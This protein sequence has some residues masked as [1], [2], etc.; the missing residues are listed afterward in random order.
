M[1]LLDTNIVSEIM[2]PMPDPTVLSWFNQ[3]QIGQVYVSAVTE[4][5]IRYGAALLPAGR[6]RTALQKEI[7]GVFAE[8][9]SDQVLPF[10]H[11]ATPHFAAVTAHRRSLG[12]PIAMADAMIAAI[13]LA[14][15]CRLATRNVKDFADTG[16]DVIDPFAEK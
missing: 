10:D 1:I 8:D 6:R 14:N 11:D 16:A 5:E 15:G 7:E 13:A 2:R 9:F 4:A 12:R 3:Q